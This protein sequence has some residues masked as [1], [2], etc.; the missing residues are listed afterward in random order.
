MRLGKL[1][2]SST[3]ICTLM[4]GLVATPSY[5]GIFGP[6]TCEKL[7]KKLSQP[8]Y[9]VPLNQKPE[10][11]SRTGWSDVITYAV[12]EVNYPSCFTKDSLVGAK[13]F[14]KQ[15]AIA[16]KANRQFSSACIYAPFGKQFFPISWL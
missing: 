6:S 1:L 7:L 10:E 9:Q 14:L 4:I 5:A 11:R 16:C 15:I 3:I 8:K 13:S 12:A 2:T